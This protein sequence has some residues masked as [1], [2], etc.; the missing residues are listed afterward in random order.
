MMV[1]Q[2]DKTATYASVEQMLIAHVVHCLG[3]TCERLEQ[4]IEVHLLDQDR[5]K[6]GS[7]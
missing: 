6:A 3:R 7:T 5:D 1:H 2:S 4:S